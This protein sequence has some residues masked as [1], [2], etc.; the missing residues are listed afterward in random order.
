MLLKIQ[1]NSHCFNLQDKRLFS[2]QL[3]ILESKH[4]KD[5]LGFQNH[6]SFCILK[7]FQQIGLV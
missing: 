2:H 7:Y 3:D 5:N 1:D 6:R 4:I